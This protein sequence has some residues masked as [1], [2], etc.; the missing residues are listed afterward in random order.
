MRLGGSMTIYNM[1]LSPSSINTY[2]TCAYSW[3]LRYVKG[4]K[5][6][7]SDAGIFGSFNHKVYEYF[8][9]FYTSESDPNAVMI[10]AMN[11]YSTSPKDTHPN[12]EPEYEE[13]A[14]ICLENFVSIIEENPNATPLHRELRCENPI[15]NTVAIV[16]VVYPNKIVDYKTST[17][18]TIKPKLPNKIQATMC[19]QNLLQVQGIEVREV[20]FWY[21]RFKKYQMITVDAPLI[22]EV[23]DIIAHVRNS[24]EEDRFQKDE[25]NCF[26]CDYKLICNSEKRTLKHTQERLVKKNA[27]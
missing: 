18:Y 4:I 13:A 7:S 25:K 22:K 17:Q 5:I 20:E 12:I 27:H 21:M 23:D 16:D 1:P 3:Y 24:I 26:F 19:S 6:G 10:E 15:N 11:K 8:W 9:D 14:Y 2:L